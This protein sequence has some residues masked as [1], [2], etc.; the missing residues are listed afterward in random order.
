[1]KNTG[2]TDYI[3]K[4]KNNKINQ[5]RT[6][7]MVFAFNGTRGQFSW[8]GLTSGTWYAK[9][10]MGF[11]PAMVAAGCAHASP[12]LSSLVASF[13]QLAYYT[14]FKA[15]G[16]TRFLFGT[17]E[18]L[19]DLADAFKFDKTRYAPNDMIAK[20]G[21]D[22]YNLGVMKFVPVPCDLFR[23]PE[24]FGT[25]WKKRILYMDLS[26]ARLT[27]LRGKDQIEMG[28]TGDINSGLTN[29]YV[30]WF[31]AANMGTE[32]NNP[33]GGFYMDVV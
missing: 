2:T 17:D 22:E 33:L 30:D 11:Y 13:K 28:Q 12:T 19:G 25:Q 4:D 1:M 18:I 10:T 20:L 3:D 24:A 8:P 6:D 5:L 21:L 9:S 29:I 23:A 15:E 14:N 27:K 16:N 32:Y 31:V 26:N 7:M